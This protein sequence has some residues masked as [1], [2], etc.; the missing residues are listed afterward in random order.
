MVVQLVGLWRGVGERILVMLEIVLE[1]A[2]SDEFKFQ[3]LWERDVSSGVHF[4]PVQFCGDLVETMFQVGCPLG[5]LDGVDNIVSN[6]IVLVDVRVSSGLIVCYPIL[7]FGEVIKDVPRELWFGFTN[8]FGSLEL[9]VGHAH[10]VVQH[11]VSV[12]CMRMYG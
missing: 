9:L 10:E 2:P 7:I 6:F 11:L 1:D 5:A 3:L 4:I 8:K 12:G